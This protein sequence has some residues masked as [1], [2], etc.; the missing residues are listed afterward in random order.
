MAS[1]RETEDDVA[2]SG[3]RAAWL[4]RGLEALVRDFADLDADDVDCGDSDKPP[5]EPG[6][7]HFDVVIVGSGYGGAVAAY[8]LAASMKARARGS[9]SWSAAASI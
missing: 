7:P 1:A 9:A 5:A 4:S 8:E 3:R 6:P 2:E